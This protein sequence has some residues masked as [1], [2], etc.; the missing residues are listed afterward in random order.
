MRFAFFDFPQVYPSAEIACK[1]SM[2]VLMS[3]CVGQSDGRECAGKTSVWNNKGAL[4][5][6]LNDTNEG[7]VIADTETQDVIEA[8]IETHCH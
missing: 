2:T 3:N 5:G 7:I 4:V 6:Q 1:Y 8:T